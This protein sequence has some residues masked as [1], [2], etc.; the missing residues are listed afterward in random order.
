MVLL[1]CRIYHMTLRRT[2]SLY[3]MC[4]K[5]LLCRGILL[6]ITYS[7]LGVLVQPYLAGGLQVKTKGLT[8]VLQQY[9]SLQQTNHCLVHIAS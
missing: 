4:F 1:C 8:V 9:P 3:T 5:R 6:N 7:S 2:L